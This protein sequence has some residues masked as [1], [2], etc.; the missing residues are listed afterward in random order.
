MFLRQELI[1]IRSTA[2]RVV[3]HLAQ[4]P[5]SA[6]YFKDALLSMPVSHRQHLQVSVLLV[7]CFF[8]GR[9]IVSLVKLC[10]G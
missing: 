10:E 4:I 8:G 7:F 3:S 1:D 9:V 5:S 2:I 6:V